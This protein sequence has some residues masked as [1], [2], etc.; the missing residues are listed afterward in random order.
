MLI[1]GIIIGMLIAVICMLTEI[2]FRNKKSGIASILEDIDK[3]LKPKNKAYI[4][5]PKN[6]EEEAREKI[7]K[8]NEKTGRDTRLEEI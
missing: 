7:I 8:N 4:I 6:E 1:L 5:M 3:K 2:F